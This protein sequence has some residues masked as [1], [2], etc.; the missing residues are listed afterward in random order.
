MSK[1]RIKEVIVTD[2]EEFKVVLDNGDTLEGVKKADLTDPIT[3]ESLTLV[4]LDIYVGQ[5]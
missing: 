4:S 3:P 5:C 2:P 1:R